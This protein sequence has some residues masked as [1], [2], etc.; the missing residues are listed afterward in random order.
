[1]TH[2]ENFLA[3]ITMK[4]SRRIPA[5]ILSSGVWNV[6]RHGLTLQDVFELHPEKIAD[7][8]INDNEKVGSD[9][10]WVGADCSNILIQALGGE[11]TFNLLGEASTVDEPLISHPS[12]VDKLRIDDLESSPEIEN[13]LKIA[14]IVAE[15]AGGE[16]MIAVSQWG[17]FTMAGQLLG[18][19]KMMLTSLKDKPGIKHILEFTERLLLKYWNLFIDAGV[20]MVNQAEPLSSGDVIS[21]KLFRE[22][23]LPFMTSANQKISHRGKRKMLHICGN[24]TR[25]L[26]LIPQSGTD[27]FSM[28]YKVDLKIAR[29]KLEGKVA[30]GGQLDPTRVLLEGTAAEIEAAS[31]SCIEDA[32]QTGFV[33]IPGCDIP[34]KTKME[35]VQTM[36]ETAHHY[37]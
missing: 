31:I 8:V 16:Y 1:L 7:I 11:C 10:I 19:D 36:I 20:E 30:F 34:P 21:S 9:V 5:M 27:L 6:Y 35:N 25:I 29:E 22:L 15:R 23:S 33:L 13:L 2:K 32:G 24:T 28:D 37:K 26:D 4:K 14:R 18:M 17:P 3:G 12:E